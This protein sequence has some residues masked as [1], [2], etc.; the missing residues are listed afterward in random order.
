MASDVEAGRYAS[1]RARCIGTGPG[2]SRLGA[3][4]GEIADTRIPNPLLT[5]RKCLIKCGNTRKDRAVDTL[6]VTFSAK[7]G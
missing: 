2:R 4:R 6:E 1:A 7:H 5:V 3:D